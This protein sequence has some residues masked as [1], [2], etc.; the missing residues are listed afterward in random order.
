[1]PWN[2]QC[3]QCKA[4][5]QKHYVLEEWRCSACG[6]RGGLAKMDPQERYTCDSS[7]KKLSQS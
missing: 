1:M 3:P 6:W 4:Y 7:A 5:M 2:F